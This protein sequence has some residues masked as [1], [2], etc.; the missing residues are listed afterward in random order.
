MKEVLILTDDFSNYGKYRSIIEDG[1][2]DIN[3]RSSISEAL[4]Y[5]RHNEN[6][7]LII[8]D[9][10][11]PKFRGKHLSF[12]RKLNKRGNIINIVND[13]AEKALEDC[14][15]IG[16]EVLKKPFNDDSLINLVN[17]M[18]EDDDVSSESIDN[19]ILDSPFCD[20]ENYIT[21]E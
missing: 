12:I 9:I 1:N 4:S 20:T 15:S 5:T 19:C 21:E 8:I 6:I 2:I 7:N 14:N 11:V 13:I 18:L 17:E 3:H 10:D 16:V